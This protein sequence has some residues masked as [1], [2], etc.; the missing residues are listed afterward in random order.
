MNI[1][2]SIKPKYAEAITEGRKSFEFRKSM[3]REESIERI[4]LYSTLPGR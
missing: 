1:L 2:L 3:F 4:Y